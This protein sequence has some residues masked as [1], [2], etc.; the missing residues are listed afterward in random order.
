MENDPSETENV[1][2]CEDEENEY[3]CN[4]IFICL[5]IK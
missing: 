5:W 3:G 1:Y 4:G 2:D